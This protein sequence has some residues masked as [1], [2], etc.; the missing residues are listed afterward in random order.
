[1]ETETH[2]KIGNCYLWILLDRF[3]EAES[4]ILISFQIVES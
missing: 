2:L 1:M 3:L 4:R